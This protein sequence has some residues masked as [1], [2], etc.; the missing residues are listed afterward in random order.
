MS[1]SRPLVYVDIE[2]LRQLI[3]EIV[4]EEL[5]E[6]QGFKDIYSEKEVCQLLGISRSTALEMRRRGE[7]RFKNIGRRVVYPKEFVRKFLEAR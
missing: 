2:A 6:M 4:R 7:L 5:A 1:S 3:R